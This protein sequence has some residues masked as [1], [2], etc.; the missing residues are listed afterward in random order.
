MCCFSREVADVRGTSIFG[1][2]AEG[3]RQFLVYEM[4]FAAEEELA[5]VL[6]VPVPAGSAE[7]AVTFV[8]LSGYDDFFRDLRQGFVV[9]G[10]VPAAAGMLADESD[11]LEV[12]AV[13]SFEASFVPSARELVRLDP[14]FRLSPEV[15][16]A[17]GPTYVDWGFVVFRLKPAKKGSAADVH[18]MA[19]SFPTRSPGELFF[20]CLHVHDGAVHA[21]AAFDHRL[22]AQLS[23]GL[24]PESAERTIWRRSTGI[25]SDFVETD[26]TK[27]IVDGGALA[28]EVRLE[29][30]MPNED[31]WA[32]AVPESEADARVREL[33]RKRDEQYAAE[34]ARLRA[35]AERRAAARDR[36]ELVSRIFRA[37]IALPVA[38]ATGFMTYVGV[39]GHWSADPDGRIVAVVFA[40][41][42]LPS[43]VVLVFAVTNRA[44]WAW[45]TAGAGAGL[46][47]AALLWP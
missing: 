20:P 33:S 9:T 2:A 12:H 29:G 22:Y 39:T 46:V 7:S 11:S 25:A 26:R 19:F 17:M 6:P 31:V 24:A 40:L 18:P 37:G 30:T 3:G 42:W 16:A 44:R 41:A 35:E 27:G 21:T 45:V 14:R 32:R 47:A 23:E 1:R 43:M 38:L 15:L 5:M 10:S 4:S 36:A 34:R 28:F 8:D 13:G